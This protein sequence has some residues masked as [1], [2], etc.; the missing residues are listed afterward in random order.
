MAKF[1]V[2]F[3]VNGGHNTTESRVEAGSPSEAERKVKDKY[4]QPIEIVY[5]R[6]V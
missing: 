2:G 4:N 3:K 6:K 5:V 1:D